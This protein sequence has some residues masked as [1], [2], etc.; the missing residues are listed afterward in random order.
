MTATE[1]PPSLT[2]EQQAEAEKVYR[3]LLA[4]RAS[5][6]RQAI[7]ILDGVKIGVR[8]TGERVDV[9]IAVNSVYTD[10]VTS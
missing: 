8:A 5:G 7:V 1:P 10:A 3:H 6:V 9:A 2:A 4:L